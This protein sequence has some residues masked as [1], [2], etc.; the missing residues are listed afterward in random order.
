MSTHNDHAMDDKIIGN[1]K[2]ISKL[3]SRFQEVSGSRYNFESRWGDINKYV[4]PHRGDFTTKRTPGQKRV[5]NIYDSTAVMANE[6]LATTFLGGLLPAS[7]KWFTLAIDDM[8][9]A[10]DHEV[11]L[12]LEAATEK[13]LSIF[14]SPSS[15][16]TPQNHEL[17][18]DLMGYGT[19]CI[20]VDTVDG[21]IRFN[22]RHLSEIYIL[23]NSFGKVDTV[24]RKFKLTP[25]QAAQQWGASQLSEKTVELLENSPDVKL[26]FL[27][28]VMPREDAIEGGKSKLNLPFAS[29]HIELD[30]K[31]L[32]TEGGYNELPY[33]V[34]R[35]EKLVGEVYGRSPA[36]N[37]MPDIK[38]LNEM[39]KANIKAAQKTVD[40][41]LLMADDGVALPLRTTPGSIIYGG[42]ATDGRP[43][44]APLQTN[45]RLDIGLEVENQRREAIQKAFFVDQLSIPNN[46]R[47]TATEIQERQQ[48]RFRLLGPALGRL[49]VEYLNPLIDRVF[50]MLLRAGK[51]PPVP[52]VLVDQEI[53]V[54]YLSPLAKQQRSAD[55]EAFMR[56]FS[57]AAQ[58][59]QVDPGALDVFNL[60]RAVQG[61]AKDAGVPSK[62]LNSAE[63]VATIRAQRQQQQEQ[64][65]QAQ[66]AKEAAEQEANLT[67]SGVLPKAGV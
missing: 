12:F 9:L 14:N 32:I 19:S 20:Y 67:K 61:I 45:I 44:I 26:E 29:Y 33:L 10:Q 4:T 63:E 46:D 57:A 34:P 13:M 49:E 59:T 64:M 47:M 50:G 40:P 25:R 36:W 22:T 53:N 39:S 43:R 66:M 51:L 35:F 48:A 23:E 41:S 16:F 2:I 38:M 18:I 3:I 15:N 21:E 28:I 65:R 8:V 17:F 11:R 55:S 52:E 37:A 58:L 31:H 60:D 42:M 27:H 56:T 1:N 54:E 30:H 24:F 62:W 5:E 6:L 7:A